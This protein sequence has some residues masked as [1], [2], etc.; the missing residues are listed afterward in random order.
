MSYPKPEQSEQDKIFMDEAAQ[1][2]RPGDSHRAAKPPPGYPYRADKRKTRRKD[3]RDY[4]PFGAG[5]Y[6]TL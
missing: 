5:H 6:R 3:E 1:N 2:K 4:R